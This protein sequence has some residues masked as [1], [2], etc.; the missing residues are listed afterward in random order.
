[1]V[2]YLV[3]LFPIQL[4]LKISLDGHFCQ[5]FIG[6]MARLFVA[7]LSKILFLDGHFWQML[8]KMGCAERDFIA[9]RVHLFRVI[10]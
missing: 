5:I 6:K 9:Q 3:T 4:L 7:N 8:A 10:P 1:M 2:R